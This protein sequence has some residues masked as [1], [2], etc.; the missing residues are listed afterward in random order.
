MP[1][2]KKGQFVGLTKS[3][4]QTAAMAI[5]L[6]SKEPKEETK[7]SPKI[8]R[9]VSVSDTNV[10]LLSKISDVFNKSVVMPQPTEIMPETAKHLE[11][12]ESN[13]DELF[14]QSAEIEEK[15]SEEPAQI[16]P[17]LDLAALEQTKQQQKELIDKDM[18]HYRN[19]QFSLIDQ[20]KKRIF[21]QAFQ[22]G[23]AAGKKEGS[24]AL[25]EDAAQIL[26]TVNDAVAEKNKMLK[27]A[28]GEVL[29]LAIKIAEQIL[30]SEISL[31]Q[32]V[33]VN[34]V[35]EAIS[36]ITD[37]DRVIVRVNKMD[38][39][40]VKMNRDRLL[41]QMGD[42]KNFIIQEDSRID[43]GGCIIETDLGYIDAT[44]STKL[45]SI[46]HAIQKVYD[47]ELAEEEQ[48]Q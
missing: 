24:K 39:E 7:K 26:K 1:L 36:K 19:H 5:G 28:R 37:K 46:E 8:I 27:M 23:L 48:G 15:I 12:K 33:C 42:I 3:A 47:E 41:K 44:I 43:Q 18:Q 21:D 34:I 29:K 35:A 9:G 22:E 14:A 6:D 25:D 45:T 4:K 20:E 10:K 13:S 31:N 38:A 32:A 11:S 17:E 30:K 2:L 16:E 40:F